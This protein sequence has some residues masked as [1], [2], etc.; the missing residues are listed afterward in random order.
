MGATGAARADSWTRGGVT[1]RENELG[2][3]RSAAARNEAAGGGLLVGHPSR[4]PKLLESPPA[5]R[6]YGDT[7]MKASIWSRRAKPQYAIFRVSP[8]R[9]WQ[10]FV[11]AARP[12]SH[13]LRLARLLVA[14]SAG[15][16]AR[17][18]RT[19]S[20]EIA[21]HSS[22]RVRVRVRLC[23]HQAHALGSRQAPCAEGVRP[24]RSQ[25]RA[26]SPRACTT[27]REMSLGCAS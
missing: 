25:P 26:F 6:H 27:G 15:C 22:L 1:R 16:R 14:A 11:R 4:T 10:S 7:V 24:H 19:D 23:R 12:V 17:R 20:I 13:A 3:A 2:A 9:S 8:R 18:S 5:R 21:S